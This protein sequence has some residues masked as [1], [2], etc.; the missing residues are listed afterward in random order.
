MTRIVLAVLAMVSVLAALTTFAF[1]AVRTQPASTWQAGAGATDRTTVLPQTAAA[2]GA[3]TGRASRVDRF[4]PWAEEWAP[5]TGIPARALAAYAAA[6]LAVRRESPSCRLNWATLAG[7]GWVETG[8]GSHDGV[9]LDTNGVARPAIIG[10]TLDGT[11]FGR[12]PDTDGGRLDGNTTWDHA[13][14]PLQFT[15]AS[16][17]RWA[18]DGDGD[19]FR[20]PQ[21]V[22]DAALASA[23]YLC[24]SGADLSTADG[25]SEAVF[26]YNHSNEYVGQVYAAA[27][28]YALRTR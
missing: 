21:D 27:K 2:P 5:R 20:D 9:G 11:S 6:D 18:A 16:W 10:P 8:H 4:V 12:V 7:I 28:E 26:S 23:R 22:D 15:P 14:G 1:A 19:G 13:V 17:K 25:W 3:S 24:A